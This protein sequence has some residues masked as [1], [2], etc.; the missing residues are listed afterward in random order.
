[1]GTCP[2]GHQV[3]EGAA[4]C[5][6]CGVEL[7]GQAAATEPGSAD[8]AQGAGRGRQT[9]WLL[10]GVATVLAVTTAGL[11]INASRSS[12]DWDASDQHAVAYVC[13]DITPEEV[14]HAT[15]HSRDRAPGDSTSS[16]DDYYEPT[17]QYR[18][19][20]RAFA[21]TTRRGTYMGN[22]GAIAGWR[23]A[24]LDNPGPLW[25]TTPD[26]SEVWEPL[27]GTVVKSAE[28]DRYDLVK[29]HEQGKLPDSFNWQPPGN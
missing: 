9:R 19:K 4:S 3:R 21:V 24:C 13:G 10:V 14:S 16:S 27:N 12:D 23:V 28:V 15:E 22:Q 1:M 8:S 20:G 5:A 11:W 29:L 2:N 26:G 25:T 7:P 6:T 18:T 17:F